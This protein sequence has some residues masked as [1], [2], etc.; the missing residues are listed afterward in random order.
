MR[1]FLVHIKYKIIQGDNKMIELFKDELLKYEEVLWCGQ[2][3]SSV[4]FTGSDI[5]LVP[6]SISWGGFAI[7]WEIST[8]TL[9][10]PFFFGLFGIPFV[11]IGLY[12]IFGRFIYKGIKKKHTYYAITNR[13][14]LIL[15]NLSNKNVDAEFITQIPCINKRVRSDGKGT[16]KFGNSFFFKGM[17]SNTGMDFFGA[18]YGKDVPTF[19][20][21]DDI[22]SV[23]R[24]VNE[25]RQGH[26]STQVI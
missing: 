20:D 25:L 13:R 6:F 15:T 5:F 23:Y 17:Y 14:V 3:D 1:G 21:I 16:I 19:Y 24:L 8:I 4:I 12:F 18:G 10:A 2:P 26:S 7:F 9:G 11:L 22:D